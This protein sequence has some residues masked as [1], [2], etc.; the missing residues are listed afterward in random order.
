MKKLRP[1]RRC[2]LR[3][4]R[5]MV[6]PYILTKN[7]SHYNVL[8]KAP[9]LSTSWRDKHGGGR[10]MWRR[11]RII[12]QFLV[13]LASQGML[14]LKT[15][16]DPLTFSNHPSQTT[17]PSQQLSISWFVSVENETFNVVGFRSNNCI[18]HL[19]INFLNFLATKIS[20]LET[21]FAVWVTVWILHVHDQRWMFPICWV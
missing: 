13:D 3:F 21:T 11:R 9:T 15:T 17:N 7:K 20:V 16:K 2:H 5:V 18:F 14:L 12:N 8:Y 6:D 19:S 4:V 10:K 1:I